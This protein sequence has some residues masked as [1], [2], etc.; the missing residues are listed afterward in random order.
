VVAANLHL[1]IETPPSLG[2]AQD[3]WRRGR[4]LRFRYLSYGGEQA[5]DREVLP[6]R[7]YSRWGH[8]YLQGREV[9]AGDGA[10]PK[11]F[12]IDRM[13][14]AEVGDLGFDPPLDTEIPE[15]FD[16]E[17]HE[18]TVRLRLSRAQ[19]E[20]LPRPHR[21]ARVEPCD[22]GADG[23][24]DDR[25][26]ADVVVIGDRALE[27]VLVCLDPDVAV[28]TPECRDLQRAHAARLLGA[29]ST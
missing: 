20:G 8:W 19:L 1:A 21:V 17:E 12:R 23:G 25:V 15:W 4:S 26:E 6:Y 5:T 11:Q 28:V 13:V 9:D 29:F 2:A 24:A 18:R 27:Y 10:D 22:D 3:A 16:L 14:T 7:V